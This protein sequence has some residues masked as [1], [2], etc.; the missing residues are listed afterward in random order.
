MNFYRTFRRCL[1]RRAYANILLKLKLTLIILTTV[2]L[3]VSATG[4]A[5][6]TLKEKGTPLEQIIQKISKQTGYDLFYDA[7]TISRALPVT[8]VLT[9]ASLNEALAICFKN[10]P[11]TYKLA[12]KTIVIQYSAPTP[13]AATEPLT[14]ISGKILDESGKPISGVS[15]RIKGSG[16]RA[17]ASRSDGSFVIAV[18]SK[19]DVLIFSYIGYKTQ[20]VKLKPNQEPLIIRMEIEEK[21]MNEV[22][23]STGIFK[24]ADK[25]F[26]GSSRTV[27]AKELQEFGNRNLLVS[28]RNIDPSFNIIE[29][30]TMGSDPNRL[31]DVQIRGNSS[32]PN[33]DNLDNIAGLNTP[34]IIL[35]GFQSTLAKMLDININ[36]IE[37]VTIL[38]D[39]SATAIYGSR[40]SNGVVVLTT[41]LP[42]P[43]ALR[44]SYRAD[45][46]IEVADLSDYHVLDASQKLDLEKKAGLYDYYIVERDIQLK[47][48][49]NYLLN[50]VNSGVNTNWLN[51]P[52]RTGIGQRH[53]FS[54]SGGDNTFRYGA[55]VQVNN[56]QGAMKGSDRNTLNGTVS[57]A[58]TYKNVKFSNQLMITEGRSAVSPYGSFSDYVK[59]N[60]YWKAFDDKGNALKVLGDP[61][62]NDYQLRWTSLPLNPLYNATL[63]GFEK[64][65]TS[66][67]INNSAIEWTV[68]GGLQIR[69]QLGLT[70]DTQQNDK[71]RPADHTAFA[72]YAT[73]DLF[74]KGDYNYGIANGF[75][76]DGGL[77]LQY[78]GTFNGKHTL[79][80]GLDYN[81]RQSENSS[82]NF[83]A[84]G[85]SNSN[86][87]FISMALQYARDKKP[88]G[89]ES[90][91]RAMGLTA[92]VN[93]IYDNR[94]FADASLRMDGSSQFGK[95]NLIAPFWSVGAGWNLH[96]EAFLKGNK[97][98]ERL[99]LRGSA[100]ITGSQN[101]NAYQ[102]LST[103]R[104][105]TNDRYFNWNGAYLLALGNEDLKW[106]QALKYDIGFDAE[107]LK[108]RLRLTG[109]YYTSTT[110]DLLSSIDLPASNG[111]SSYVEN[112][113]K[114]GN[115]GFELRTTGIIINQ[116]SKGL[117]W[118]I[119]AGV[120]QNRNKILKT[121]QALKNAQKGRQQQIGAVPSALYFEGYS[122]STIWVV[123]SLGIDP[124]N[125]KEVYLDIN[126]KPTYIWSGND[127][128][129]AGN[130][131]PDFMGN[132]STMVRYKA[133]S[134]N[135]SFGYRFG[136]QLYNQTLINKVE[137]ADYKYNVDSRV[138]SDRWQTP[139]DNVAFK[140]LMVTN[141]TYRSSRFVQ[142]ENTITCQNINLQY[143]LKSG[144]LKRNLSLSNL[145][146]MA[147][148][149][150]PFRF[151]TIKQE[152]GTIYPFSKQF[153]ASITATF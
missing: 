112:V 24:K 25:S 64:T 75:G 20:E 42:K 97:I 129:A 34:L 49:Y 9:N 94:F 114:M 27:T 69:A 40:G 1:T 124:G 32:L 150:E 23:I 43:G 29:S 71:F 50:D 104:Y 58:Y 132:F 65:K 87:D 4:F 22:V 54:L 63:N 5:Q 82:Y 105:Y 35:D 46:N 120:G 147:N 139:G 107:F 68:L 93:Y 3:Q 62:N 51:I 115:K 137:N 79:F 142:N 118:S 78:T 136:G 30:N 86:F 144:Y 53:N 146:L 59:M 100:G 85:F 2:I 61:G 74:R 89:T 38:K 66:Q 116:S 15:I 131:D 95:N 39:A 41:K 133:L 77:N 11:F 37:S 10:Q 60:P 57:L 7:S 113:G 21:K 81:I 122:T 44:V 72:N 28:L 143:N 135:A 138:Y 111:F 134:L 8:V 13:L 128:R 6:V 123:P 91:T 141:P 99:K 67:L 17:I 48:Y 76:Y 96:N 19:N 26:T 84:E 12:S 110:R 83:L 151:S 108:G 98:I 153:S 14:N 55:S 47:R 52:L 149:D 90:L 127:L 119:T 103:Y 88:D 125:G 18:A 70:K 80:A 145:L 101:F 109:D 36:E 16:E 130:S 152:R 33:I 126:G 31:P 45:V 117:Y 148:V 92:N 140:G 56:I 102:A 106:Q 121:S 73:A